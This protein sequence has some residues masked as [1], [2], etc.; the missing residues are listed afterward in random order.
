MKTL[1]TT[2]TILTPIAV[3]ILLA[4]TSVMAQQT[5][6]EKG[7]YI[8]A[9]AGQAKSYGREGIFDTNEL[10]YKRR[11]WKAST[12]YRFSNQI[13]LALNYTDLGVVEDYDS[14]S[15]LESIGGRAYGASAIY[16]IPL[17]NSVNAHAKFGLA[18]FSGRKN[19]L[20]DGT[21]EYTGQHATDDNSDNGAFYGVGMSFDVST[22]TS[23][24]L[25]WERYDFDTVTDVV[26]AG[27]R[28]TFGAIPAPVAVVAPVIIAAAPAPKP[29]PVPAPVPVVVL[30]PLQVNVYFDNDS[31]ALTTEALDILANAQ[32]E[33]D[34]DRVES[35]NVSGFASAVGNVDYNQALSERRAAVVVQHIKA[36]WN[37][38][39][40]DVKVVSHGEESLINDD[41]AN[42]SRD[43]R[44][45]VKISF[46]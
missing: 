43:R 13:A 18:H 35:I 45:M 39:N 5:D 14:R 3:G 40:S 42:N 20:I 11:A 24:M 1:K 10:S 27:L 7:W 15:A 38:N 12:G 26:S 8:Q 16:N 28:Y 37:L 4:S 41:V 30:K 33:L 9:D 19:R 17:S 29:A 22:N 21:G 31:S 25:E 2:R 34:S 36:N 23:L 44:V 46:N 32:R 6:V